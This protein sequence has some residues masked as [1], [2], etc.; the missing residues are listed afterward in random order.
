MHERPDLRCPACGQHRPPAAVQEQA[1]RALAHTRVDGS[2]WS[3]S[4]WL[5]AV[6]G[7]LGEFANV[8]KKFERGELTF[9]EYEVQAK[10]E[11]ADVQTYLDILALRCLDE[12]DKV[13]SKGVDLGQATIDKF[14]E[15]SHRVGADVWLKPKLSDLIKID[16]EREEVTIAGARVSGPVFRQF[17]QPSRPGQWFR[18]V[19]TGDVIT[20]ET[21][22]K[23]DAGDAG[24]SGAQVDVF[25]NERTMS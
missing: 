8:R 14:N 4:Q 18:I 1:R 11:L 15:V 24:G 16:D 5:Q 7:E 25:E 17:A 23:D 6:V 3:P 21:K 13:C 12:G 2:D 22:Q 9:D 10:K 20:V 19:S